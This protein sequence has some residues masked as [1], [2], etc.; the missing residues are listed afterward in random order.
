MAL[1]MK[2]SLLLSILAIWLGVCRVQTTAVFAHFIVT[3]TQNFTTE[4][5]EINMVFAQQ[6]HIDAFALNMAYSD[7]TNEPS[8]VN[9]FKTASVVGFQL[10]F[11]FNYAGNGAWP[12]STVINLLTK[13]GSNNHY[14]QYKGKP[15]VSTFKGP[16]SCYFVPDWSSLGTKAALKASPGVPDGL[17]SW[18][19]WPWGPNDMD[20][21]IDTSYMQYL[22]GKPY[23]IPVSP[24]FYTNLPGK[25][26][27]IGPLH[28][29]AYTAFDIGTATI[30]KEGIQ[31]WFRRA[32]AAACTNGGTSSNTITQFQIEFPP[33]EILKDRVFYSALL[34]SPAD[35]SSDTPDGGISIYYGSVPFNG[36]TGQVVVTISHNGAV[37]AS[38][39][40]ESINTSIYLGGI[41]NWN[42][43]IRTTFADTTIS[44]TPELRIISVDSVA[45]MNITR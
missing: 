16:Q 40:G 13:Y 23:I 39:E 4:D 17:F 41:Q 2:S 11:S 36:N 5:W 33:T 22:D 15:F 44:T 18:A 30:T 43:W 7:P 37:I 25:S 20:T 21:Y 29:N 1:D 34:S 38:M 31:V 14:Y 19:G 9:A 8:L 26:H 35:V 27:Y 32:P 24:W 10:F 6:A 28:E 45:L 42:P 12:K 3:N